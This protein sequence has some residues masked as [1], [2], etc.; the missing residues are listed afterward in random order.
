MGR[1]DFSKALLS[2][3]LSF[4]ILFVVCSTANGEAESFLYHAAHS[5]TQVAD[6]EIDA[7]AH[8]IRGRVILGHHIPFPLQ[9]EHKIGLPKLENLP[10][11]QRYRYAIREFRAALRK[12]DKSTNY[13][14]SQIHS[15]LADTYCS[16]AALLRG[17]A[18]KSPQT[19]RFLNHQSQQFFDLCFEQSRLALASENGDLKYT[20]AKSLVGAYITAREYKKALEAIEEFEREKLQ[21]DSQ[22]DH[23]VIRLK[24]LIHLKLGQEKEA[25]LAYEEWIRRGKVDSYLMPGDALYEKLRALQRKTGH[26]NNLPAA[27][28]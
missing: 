25:G 23:G 10:K 17:E 2:A 14:A 11:E 28:G 22:E 18:K 21:P 26:P 3:L 12:R 24:A 6:T 8:V 15:Y 16:L 27:Q 20:L 5:Q 19:N 13:S 1:G 4:N 9:R 7:D